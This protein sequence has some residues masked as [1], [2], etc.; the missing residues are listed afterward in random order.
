I[1][2]NKRFPSAE[3]INR[4]AKALEVN[5]ADLFAREEPESMKIMAS[6]QELKTRFERLM[7]KA[8]DELFC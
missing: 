1:E 5:V 7:N 6:K 3:N 2:I 4:I 8:I